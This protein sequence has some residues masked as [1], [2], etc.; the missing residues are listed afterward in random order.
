MTKGFTELRE[1]LRFA[2]AMQNAIKEVLEDKKVNVL[3]AFKFVPV[4]PTIKPAFEGLGNPIERL[5]ELTPDERQI[6]HDEL[7]QEFDI[8]N[9]AI[10]ALVEMTIENIAETIALAKEWAAIVKG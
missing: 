10:E 3:D 7:I 1:L 9:D 2:F 6:L 4:L 5:R 8:P